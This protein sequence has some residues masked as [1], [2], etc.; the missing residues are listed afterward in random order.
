MSF[1]NFRKYKE[2]HLDKY[3]RIGYTMSR[4]KKKTTWKE[5]TMDNEINN[6]V[7][8]GSV[9]SN[10]LFTFWIRGTQEVMHG[11]LY[12]GVPALPVR[13]LRIVHKGDKW[14]DASFMLV[15]DTPED[16]DP[17]YTTPTGG[18]LT[19]YGNEEYDMIYVNSVEHGREFLQ[20]EAENC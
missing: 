1:Y 10:E 6:G 15:V 16:E 9:P 5:K 14:D 13:I 4:Y 19:P 20:H 11:Q 8:H 17:F 7:T 3:Q 18:A 12:A 2:K